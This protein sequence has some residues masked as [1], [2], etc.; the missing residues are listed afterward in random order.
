MNRYQGGITKCNEADFAS[1]RQ[2]RH[3]GEIQIEI[4]ERRRKGRGLR[5]LVTDRLP[6]IHLG[7]EDE[8]FNYSFKCRRL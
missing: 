1:A 4:R 2:A 5:N 6:K 3:D 8:L 7:G